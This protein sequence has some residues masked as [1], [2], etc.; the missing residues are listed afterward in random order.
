MHSQ[1]YRTDTSSHLS[2]QVSMPFTSKKSLNAFAQF[3]VRF[4]FRSNPKIQINMLLLPHSLIVRLDLWSRP[5][6]SPPTAWPVYDT[7]FEVHCVAGH[8]LASPTEP[9]LVYFWRMLVCYIDNICK[10]DWD[11]WISM[12]SHQKCIINR[13]II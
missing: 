6:H 11:S 8:P 3:A 7:I 5:L 13:S 4:G 9:V 2:S 10:Y 1:R 12:S